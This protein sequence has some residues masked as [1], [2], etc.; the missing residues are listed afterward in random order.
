MYFV[1]NFCHCLLL[2]NFAYVHKVDTFTRHHCLVEVADS[3]DTHQLLPTVTLGEAL[4]Q[5]L[6]RHLILERHR[7]LA[8]GYTQQ[9]SVAKL[10][11]LEK[12]Q[13]AGAGQEAAI[14]VIYIILEHIIACIER[15]VSFEQAHLVCA[16]DRREDLDSLASATLH[17]FKGNVALNNLEH[18]FLDSLNILGAQFL[19]HAAVVA[20]GNRILETH[21]TTGEKLVHRL[22]H[23]KGE[24][25]YIHFHSIL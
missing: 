1:G 8:V 18:I 5:F 14:V 20:F 2:K 3:L 6:L 17:A 16:S 13:I 11:N 4:L 10:F 22:H 21:R 23:H 12:F 7:R 19:V 9:H 25:T 24:R 15:A